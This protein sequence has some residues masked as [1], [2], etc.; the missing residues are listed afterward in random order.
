MYPNECKRCFRPKHSRAIRRHTSKESANGKTGQGKSLSS[1]SAIA[2]SQKQQKEAL[3]RA[4]PD[5]R[6][7]IPPAPA[8]RLGPIISTVH[9]YDSTLTRN[10]GLLVSPLL[11]LLLGRSARG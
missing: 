9:T 1:D 8:E 4:A 3:R 11:E 2:R 6:E 5:A 10:K 7:R